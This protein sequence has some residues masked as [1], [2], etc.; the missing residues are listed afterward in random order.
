ML[1]WNLLLKEFI[2]IIQ[3]IMFLR[4][5][6]TKNKFLAVLLTKLYTLMIHLASQFFTEEKMQSINL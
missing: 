1:I 2:V 3:T 6:S 5:E 4:P